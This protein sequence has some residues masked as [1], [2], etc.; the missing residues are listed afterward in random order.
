MVAEYIIVLAVVAIIVVALAPKFQH[1]SSHPNTHPEQTLDQTLKPINDF[2]DHHILLI[3]GVTGLLIVG[4]LFIFPYLK[5]HFFQEKSEEFDKIDDMKEEIEPVAFSFDFESFHVPDKNIMEKA[6]HLH[7]TIN[8]LQSKQEEID[9]EMTFRLTHVASKE[10]P[11]LLQQF[12]KLNEKSQQT[13]ASKMLESLEKIQTKMDS[14]LETIE[15]KHL[16][17]FHETKAFID[18]N[19]SV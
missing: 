3:I 10:F 8:S 4:S 13:Q 7:L 19:H 18:S 5:N 14:I 12:M 9:E 17:D 11:L 6:R 15:H 2:L 16:Q 1:S